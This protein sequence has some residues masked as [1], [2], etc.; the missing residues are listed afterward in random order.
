MVHVLREDLERG[1]E[2]AHELLDKIREEV[3]TS[4]EIGTNGECNVDMDAVKI[5][6]AGLIEAARQ[7]KAVKPVKGFEVKVARQGMLE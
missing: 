7:I 4:L 3:R 1:I 6:C 5:M 2:S